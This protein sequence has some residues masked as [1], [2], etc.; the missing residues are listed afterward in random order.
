MFRRRRRL[1]CRRCL[2]LRRR[3]SRRRRAKEARWIT[4]RAR[5]FLK[6][7]RTPS[8]RSPGRNRRQRLCPNRWKRRRKRKRR[9]KDANRRRRRRPFR[10][11]SPRRTS[12]RKPPPRRHHSLETGDDN[13][14][15]RESDN[16]GL[17]LTPRG[18]RRDARCDRVGLARGAIRASRR[19]AAD[20]TDPE[21]DRTR[22]RAVD[23]NVIETTT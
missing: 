3:N 7:K 4:R 19:R 15:I 13:A 21:I 1:Q 20:A 23:A 10:M 5:R 2:R 12:A 11:K 16:R 17:D 6:R 22:D 8:S 9:H 14:T 18:R